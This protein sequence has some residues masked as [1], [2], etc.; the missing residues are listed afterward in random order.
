[1]SRNIMTLVG[2]MCADNIDLTFL[3]AD[4]CIIVGGI[5]GMERLNGKPQYI[6][7][8]KNEDI[9]KIMPAKQP[10]SLV[11]TPRNCLAK[12][13]FHE[14]IECLPDFVELEKYQWNPYTVSS[15]LTSL[16][17]SLWIG[18]SVIA[19]FNYLLEPDKEIPAL[20]AMLKLHPH[21]KF[22]Y[23]REKN[24][25]AINWFKHYPNIE[26]SDMKDFKNFYE[27]YKSSN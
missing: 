1:M 10:E 24:K 6:C 3:N 9:A 5:K 25:N 17:L 21:T 18:S 26:Q 19:L 23:V 8:N 13:I 12:Y 22:L 20:E 11:L 7:V 15:Q 27:K 2:E 16:A 14:G 4:D